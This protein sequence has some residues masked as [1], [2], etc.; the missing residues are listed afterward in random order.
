MCPFMEFVM[1][2]DHSYT[3]G[4]VRSVSNYCKLKQA[5][6]AGHTKKDQ[7]KTETLEVLLKRYH[8][9]P[10]ASKE[11]EEIKEKIILGIFFLFPY[12]V[13]K[14]RIPT[15]YVE[16]AIQI[17]LCNALVAMEHFDPDKGCS[18]SNYLIGY[19]RNAIAQTYRA[20]NVVSPGAARRAIIRD[21]YADDRNNDACDTSVMNGDET[22]RP[23]GP[24]AGTD[25]E[26][27]GEATAAYRAGGIVPL[28]ETR[29][30]DMALGCEQGCSVDENVHSGQLREWLEEGL[31]PEAG[32]VTEEER[33]VLILHY[34]LFGRKPV[35]YRDIAEMRKKKG[36][37]SANSRISQIKTQGEKKLRLWFKQNGLESY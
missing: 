32:V 6:P 35:K 22:E 8:S 28:D 23:T 13:K 27:E 21:I 19:C 9:F 24:E 33:Q 3:C 5:W 11:K 1:Y 4:I 20:S 7:N 29:L 37:G 12:I 36:K 30:A 2:T 25:R 31:S 16:D 17:M 34:G 10:A 18:F 15:C 26:S 14:Y